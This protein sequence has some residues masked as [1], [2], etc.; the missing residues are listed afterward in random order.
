MSFRKIGLL[1]ASILALSVTS[2]ASA[3]DPESGDT[4]GWGQGNSGGNGGG[5]WGQGNG[6][7]RRREGG[8]GGGGGTSWEGNDDH[9]MVVHHMGFGY[10]G[11]QGIPYGLGLSGGNGTTL[12]INSPSVGMVYWLSEGLGLEG[13]IGFGLQSGST[14]QGNASVSDPSAWGFGLHAGLPIALAHAKHYT[15]LLIPYLNLA[16]G[17]GTIYSATDT[18]GKSDTILSGFLFQVGARVGAE[19]NF[20]FMGIPQLALR[21]TLGL[22]ID[23]QSGSANVGD[24]AG[25]GNTT[26]HSGFAISTFIG[27]R[28]WDIFKGGIEAIYYL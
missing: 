28:P 7:P 18:S 14:S 21:G 20:G 11:I 24:G 9:N 16:F 15:F 17:G 4:G 6:A 12:T 25:G 3:Q 19:I 22:G 5:G 8:G 27:E 10:F 26:S 13:A 2:V 23:F 1:V